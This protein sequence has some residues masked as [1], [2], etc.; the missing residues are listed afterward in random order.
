MSRFAAVALALTLWWPTIVLAGNPARGAIA[1]AH[2]LATAAGREMLEQGGNAFDAAVAIG[3]ALGVVEPAGSGLGG[4][5]YWLLHRARDE[6][7]VM[8]DA[9][10][11]A[12]GA[13]SADMYL[14]AKGDV[15]PRLS[16]D[17]P[18]A[19]A[20][21][22]TPAALVH[23]SAKYGRLPL[24]AALVPAIRLARHGVPVTPRYR[25]LARWRLNAFAASPAAARVFLN[26]GAVPE[27]GFV[28]HQPDLAIVLQR[29][30]E[31]GRNGFYSGSTARQLV[32]GVRQAGGIWSLDDL[33]TYKVVERAPITGR[34]RGLRITSASLPSSGGMVLMQILNI[35]GPYQLEKLS[36]V[37]RTHLIVEAMRRAYRDRARYLG[38]PDFINVDVDKLLS[39]EYTAALRRTIDP[40][41]ATPS[42]PADVVA[43]GDSGDQT[44][45]FS[46]FDSEGNRV[47]AT[48]TINSAFG[49]G[50]VPPGTGVLLNN[51]MDDF[52][53]KPGVANLYGLVGA[54]ANAIAPGKRPLSSMTPTFLESDDRVVVLGTPGGSRIITMVLLVALEVTARR[55][56][57]EDWV[58]LSR[59]HHQFLP[60]VIQIEPGAIDGADIIALR[61]MGH[62]VEQRNR[63]YG[64]MQIVTWDKAL[65]RSDAAS[66]PRGEGEV[67]VKPKKQAR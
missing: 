59:F 15:I 23:I 50:F 46:V 26:H 41:R 31:Q 1:S 43:A 40:E 21:P 42:N 48:L 4:G 63:R 52:V 27:E 57:P 24:A 49:S 14:D 38:D 13:A 61:A 32:A 7:E 17:G 34:Y 39:D 29:I 22:G 44:T 55:G 33:S 30:S 12:P 66:D 10:E 62:R 25:R 64:N 11:R 3:A 2:P 9:R 19:A 37:E 8:I 65:N 58:A 56:G 20:I 45:H 28:I 54:E 67:W 35:L 47:A 16:L 5:G 51:E 36:R 53:A 18:L 60:D 6:F